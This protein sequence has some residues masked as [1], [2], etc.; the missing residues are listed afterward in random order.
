MRLIHGEMVNGKGVDIETRCIHYQSELDI[1][2]IKFKCCA[3]WYPC[4]RCHQELAKH[5]AQVG[6][7]GEFEAKSILCGACG[8]QL[9]IAEYLAC[10]FKCPDCETGFKP[11]CRNHYHLYFERG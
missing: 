6:P 4:F 3:K 2:A 11:G 10:N 7:R 1:V 8:H 5:E 9:T